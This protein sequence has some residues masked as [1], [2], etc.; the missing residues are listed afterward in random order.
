MM[1]NQE[2]IYIWT[3]KVWIMEAQT[4]TDSNSMMTANPHRVFSYKGSRTW[5]YQ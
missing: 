2:N 3:P 4:M 1:E 5:T